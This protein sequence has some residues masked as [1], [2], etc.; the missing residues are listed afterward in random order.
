MSRIRKSRGLAAPRNK[1]FPTRITT[2]RLVM[3]RTLLACQGVARMFPT[4]FIRLPPFVSN[5][6]HFRPSPGG[7]FP[8][9]CNRKSREGRVPLGRQGTLR[10]MP[11]TAN[12]SAF[13]GLLERKADRHSRSAWNGIWQ[14]P[15]R[16]IYDISFANRLDTPGPSRRRYRPRDCFRYCV[17]SRRTA[18]C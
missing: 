1:P 5:K 16:R 18:C 2:A 4:D 11:L 17:G 3:F 7:I 14:N 13:S 6:R 15:P 8:L 10:S 9:L 12:H